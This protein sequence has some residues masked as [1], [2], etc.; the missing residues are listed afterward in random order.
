M[1]VEIQ[2]VLRCH[3]QRS[4]FQISLVG[5]MGFGTA[6]HLCPGV[7]FGTDHSA[8]S[9]PGEHMHTQTCTVSGGLVED[10]GT[11]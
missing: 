3:H 4:S 2:A 9:G 7:L 8:L 11:N 1:S 6:P 10:E 5:W